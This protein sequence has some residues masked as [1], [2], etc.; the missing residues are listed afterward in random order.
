[1]GFALSSGLVLWLW[2]LLPR[3]AHRHFRAGRGGAALRRY[4][5]LRAITLDPERRVAVDVSL[6]ACLLAREETAAARATLD[7]LDR[8]HLDEA[9]RAAFLNNQAY[10][11]VRTDGDGREALRLSEE[12]IA[13]RPHVVGF[14]HTRALALLAIGRLDEAIRTLDGLWRDLA[15]SEADAQLE[16]ERCYDLGRAWQRKGQPDYAR[17]YFDRARRAAPGSIW[18]RR[19]VEAMPGTDARGTVLADLIEA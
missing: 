8:E 14:H 12:A 11:L 10:L 3:A 1:V 16:A 5:L 9:T 13:L 17:D 6:A 15:A 4:R 7:R 18:G 19:A 2:L